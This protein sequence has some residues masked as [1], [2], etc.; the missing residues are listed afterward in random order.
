MPEAKLFVE[1]RTNPRLSIKIPVKYH[2]VDNQME[3]A[4]IQEWQKKEQ[5]A[6]TLDVSL[7]GLHIVVD[8]PLKVGTI[9]QFDIYLLE[10]KDCVCPYAEVIWSN[11][12]NS[13]LKFL[14]MAS[15]DV[16]E[17]KNFLEKSTVH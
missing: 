4:N 3:M 15:E 16:E 5:N 12:T 1:K 10:N 13:G 2:Q 14:M 6:Y 17:L 11:P 7:G 9:H 8:Q